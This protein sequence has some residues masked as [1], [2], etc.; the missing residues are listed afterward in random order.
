M[1]DSTQLNTMQRIG[2]M[3]ILKKNIIETISLL[4]AI[5]AILEDSLGDTDVDHL[6]ETALVEMSWVCRWAPDA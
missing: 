4:D 1:L 2:L 3:A 5:S 6:R